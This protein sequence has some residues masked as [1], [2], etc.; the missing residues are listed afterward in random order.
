MLNYPLTQ[1]ILINSI[2]Q[3]T[4]YPTSKSYQQMLIYIAKYIYR[5]KYVDKMW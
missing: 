4:L 3:L 1:N 5:Y 2:M